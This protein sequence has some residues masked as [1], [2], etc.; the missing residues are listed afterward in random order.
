MRNAN[1]DDFQA[2]V[3]QE[4]MG[5]ADDENV[6]KDKTYIDGKVDRWYDII[7]HAKEQT[8]PKVHRRT[9]PHPIESDELKLIQWQF[10]NISRRA[11]L[12]GWTPEL[13]R[14]SKDLQLRIT[15]ECIQLFDDNWERMI[16]QIEVDRREP[17]K[18]WTQ[19]KRLLGG[20]QEQAPYVKRNN[21]KVY[22][23]EDKELAFRDKWSSIFTITPED[24]L[25]FNMANERRVNDFINEH[26][27]EI[28]PFE[29]VDLDRLDPDNA[30]TRP[31]TPQLVKSII[32]NFKNKAPGM[33]RVNKVILKNLPDAMIELYT[34]TTNETLSM[35]YFPDLYKKGLFRFIGKPGKSPTSVE[36]YRPIS[37][38]EVPFK[39]FEK[40]IQ[41]RLLKHLHDNNLI[42]VNQYG[43]TKGRGTQTALAK[44]YEIVAISQAEGRGC[45][46]VSRDIK[47]A[48]DK[49]WHDGL[50][51][52][53]L[54][55]NFPD[56]LLRVLCS[57]LDNRVGRI[58]IGNF[59]GPEFPLLCGVPQGAI[60]SPTLF[61][62]FTHD[63]PVPSPHCHQLIFAD[64]HTQVVT[65][66]TTRAKHILALRTS[67]EVQRMS[68]YE[69]K[70]KISSN[71]DKFQLLSISSFKP[72]RVVVDGFNI[73]FRNSI[74]ILGFQFSG[75]GFKPH[76]TKRISLGRLHL[77]KLRRFRLSSL[78]T[79]LYLYKTLVRSRMEYPAVLMSLTP[80][81]NLN[82]LQAVQNRAVRRAFGQ[83][84]PYQSTCQFLHELIKLEPL[85]TRFHRL[86][87]RTWD[88][89]A[90]SDLDLIE[91]SNALNEQNPPLSHS[92]WPRLSPHLEG[93]PPAPKFRS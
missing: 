30:L 76:V 88:R 28:I 15:Q 64:D 34:E 6:R 87:C 53:M 49:V 62:F 47:K 84:P 67:R 73:P 5:V 43:F 2:R 20:G 48:F 32:N 83:I 61:N 11:L 1:W 14:L 8:I 7:H 3:E 25:N 57:F 86:G 29:L 36:N 18:F 80:K 55:G 78:R 42:N 17:W 77:S 33:S 4:A 45:N 31:V 38:L 21:I 24:N 91:Q 51:F 56:I 13:L 52:K 35:G 92:W 37:L 41:S 23:D 85:N 26:R 40:V 74:K 60:L 39:I 50:K 12:L 63:I 81:T 44:L 10:D 75:R 66:Q 70:W 27:D 22:S 54:H 68:D 93:D 65:H 71:Q 9:L 46:V 89:L 79:K 69:A 16:G 59:C 72:A 58:K 82:K 90:R 19:V